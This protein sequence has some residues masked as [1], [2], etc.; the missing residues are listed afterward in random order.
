[1]NDESGNAGPETE[2]R[3]RG[4]G[5]LKSATEAGVRSPTPQPIT[6]QN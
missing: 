2:G 6:Q 4:G 1:M 3:S 5:G